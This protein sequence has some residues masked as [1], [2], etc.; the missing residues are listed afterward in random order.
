MAATPS[1]ELLNTLESDLERLGLAGQRVVDELFKAIP[2][3]E[4]MDRWDRVGP[5]VLQRVRE[6][7]M[8]KGD[9]AARTYLAN[10][11]A[12]RFGGPAPALASILPDDYPPPVGREQSWAGL[13][14]H[15]KAEVR[16]LMDDGM[17]LSDAIKVQHRLWR[18]KAV[19][20]PAR[21]ARQEIS[22]A[23]VYRDE[24]DSR[25]QRVAEAGACA[26]C[27]MLDGQI[28]TSQE[29]ADGLAYHDSCR[30]DAV[31]IYAK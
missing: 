21:V 26:F 3:N 23:A 1:R 22:D 18:N 12:E 7:M 16:R 10:A 9:E 25:W 8:R 20:E 4:W 31:P 2:D 5:S 28:F 19:G 17:S 24:F 6:M 29:T 13:A 27:T 15:S 14:T 11:I 30:C